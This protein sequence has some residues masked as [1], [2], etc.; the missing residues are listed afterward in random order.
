M[1]T[2][3]LYFFTNHF[4]YGGESFVGNEIEA[5]SKFY[6]KIFLFPS[7]NGTEIKDKLPKNVEV[8]SLSQ[9]NVTG[10]FG[11]LVSNLP[12]IIGIFSLDFVKNSDK[13]NVIKKFRYN[14]SLLLN[15]L[16]LSN[17]LSEII[18]KDKGDKK[19]VSFWMDQWSLALS[20]L[21]YKKKIQSFVFRVHQHDLYVDNNPAQYIPFRYFN[22]KMTAAV[23]PDSKRGVKF[24]KDLNYFPE[25]M[26]VGH[27]GV[28]DKGTNP[29]DK[30]NFTIVSCSALLSRKRVDLI[31][32]SL[33]EIGIPVTWIHFGAKGEKGSF[34]D[35]KQKCDKLNSNIK[36]IL[37]GDVTYDELIRFYK[38]NPVN[39]FVTLTRA[40]GLPVSVIEAVSF[41][42]PVLA[43]D[44]MGL[45]DVVTEE[46]GIIISPDLEK[47]KIAIIIREFVN[48][49]KNTEEF[50]KKVKLF[51]KTNFNSEINYSNFNSFINAI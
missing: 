38:T 13:R 40:E 48:G 21:K 51:W 30:N 31:A 39:L 8:I 43:T 35:L 18:E 37:K 7:V 1:Q 14:L 49:P 24:L 45:P 20:I 22:I 10:K 46:S 47:D 29:F 36:V 34:E 33:N 17:K 42:V 26:H 15:T 5:L 2:K 4:P 16:S 6:N 23:F 3:N 25:K 50:R 41:G 9:N 12:M 11:L 44:V 19:F 28:V 32:D 27:L